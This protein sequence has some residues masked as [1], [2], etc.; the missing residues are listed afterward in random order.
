MREGQCPWA[1]VVVRGFVDTP[2]SW[3]GT[4]HAKDGRLGGENDYAFLLLPDQQFVSFI[5]SGAGDEYQRT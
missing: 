4:E 1:A 5:L 3:S 2:V